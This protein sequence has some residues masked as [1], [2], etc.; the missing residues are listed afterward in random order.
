MV[1]NEIPNEGRLTSVW[2][3][4]SD[5]SECP[6]VELISAKSSRDHECDSAIP[7]L[8]GILDRKLEFLLQAPCKGCQFY[9]L[10]CITSTFEPARCLLMAEKTESFF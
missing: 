1:I 8:A 2:W 9:S 3:L 6:L 4:F 5:L 7:R 10:K